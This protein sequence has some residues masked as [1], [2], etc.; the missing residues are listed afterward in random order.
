MTDLEH[1]ILMLSRA[2][3]DFKKVGSVMDEGQ[4]TGTTEIVVRNENNNYCCVHTFNKHN[5]I[6]LKVHSS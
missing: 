2:G 6:L 3:L 4:D 5:G 1:Y